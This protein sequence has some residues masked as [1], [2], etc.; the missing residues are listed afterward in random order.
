V[1]EKSTFLFSNPSFINGAA[2]ILDFWGLYTSYNHSST[3]MEADVRALYADWG[4]VGDDLL[5]AM[6]ELELAVEER[7]QTL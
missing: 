2:H 3:R 7:E 4:A 6:N 5:A 1:P